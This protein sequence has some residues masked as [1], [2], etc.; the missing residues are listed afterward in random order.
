MET[1]QTYATPPDASGRA[2]PR[3]IGWGKVDLK[4]GDT[5][6]VTIST[7]PRLFAEFDEARHVWH[8]PD[9]QYSVAVGNSS[10]SLPLTATVQLSAR[11]LPP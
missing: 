7:D 3:L 4:P 8:L 10:A 9:G 2:V 11:D 6:R 1:V 5:R